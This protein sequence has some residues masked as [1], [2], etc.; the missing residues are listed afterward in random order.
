MRSINLPIQLSNETGLL[1]LGDL[2]SPFLNKGMTLASFQQYGKQL[3]LR[4]RD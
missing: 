2:A 4:E 3:L 1:L